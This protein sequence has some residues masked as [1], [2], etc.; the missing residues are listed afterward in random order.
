MLTLK[1][2]VTFN[3]T[4]SLKLNRIRNRTEIMYLKTYSNLLGIY[5]LPIIKDNS[6]ASLCKKNHEHFHALSLQVEL[7]DKGNDIGSVN[8]LSS[9]LYSIF[10]FNMKG[11]TSE[12][13]SLLLFFVREM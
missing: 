12:R 1:C 6:D 4:L 7:I 8:F 5:Y 9:L 11:N 2:D 3:A 10:H 13:E